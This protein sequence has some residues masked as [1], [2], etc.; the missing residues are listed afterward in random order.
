VHRVEG[1]VLAAGLSSRSG[2]FKMALP[3]GD[4]SLIERAIEGMY[5]LVDRVLVVVGWR[6]ER[7]RELLS[8]YDKVELVTNPHYRAGMFSSVQA[9][10]S[11][12]RA[13]R[14]F[15]L[16]GDC[17]LVPAQV[18][19]Q[20]LATDADIAIPTFRGKRGHPVLM[21]GGLASEILALPREAILRDYIAHR[22][23]V[24]IEVEDDRILIDLDT[25]QDYEAM[26][27]RFEL[28]DRKEVGG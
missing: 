5:A 11:R 28:C 6:A 17:A 26:L 9:G 8:P 25:P 7:I 10:A 21:R 22:G 13:S 24:P 1:I 15:L 3:L 2:R 4:R 18:Y 27:A 19:R 16:P 23:F 12:V 20:L 14:F